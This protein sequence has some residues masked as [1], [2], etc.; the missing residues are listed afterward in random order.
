METT[1]LEIRAI[2]V[3]IDPELETAKGSGWMMEVK[4]TPSKAIPSRSSPTSEEKV[5]GILKTPQS[6]KPGNQVDFETGKGSTHG[7]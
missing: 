4:A 7:S 2:M 5:K 1:L 3:D 6:T